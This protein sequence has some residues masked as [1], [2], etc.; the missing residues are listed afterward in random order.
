MT[1]ERGPALP[2]ILLVE[3]DPND[4]V[5]AE[6]ALAKGCVPHRVFRLHDGDEAL[7]YL[8]GEPPF[9]DRKAH[10]LPILILLDLKMSRVTGFQ[11][12]TWLKTRPELSAIPVVVLTGS[13]LGRDRA[14][15]HCLGAAGY[16]IKPVE[17]TALLNIIQSIGIRWLNQPSNLP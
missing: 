6:R 16:E 17:F 3:D 2:V 1:D 10:P 13:I 15:A 5:L 11:V 12:L 4:A 7:N 8:R 9:N 14:E